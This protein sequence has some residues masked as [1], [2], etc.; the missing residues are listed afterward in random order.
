MTYWGPFNDK[1]LIYLFCALLVVLGF[2]AAFLLF[3]RL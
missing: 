1:Q 3:G 2:I